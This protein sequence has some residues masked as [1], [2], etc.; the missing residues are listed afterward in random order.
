MISMPH[1]GESGDESQ[2]LVIGLTV[3]VT[4]VLM[5]IGIIIIFV[6]ILFHY[7]YK[8]TSNRILELAM[9]SS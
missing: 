7:Y 4:I 1:V 6:Y 3:T 2:G 5:I 9:Y 8:K